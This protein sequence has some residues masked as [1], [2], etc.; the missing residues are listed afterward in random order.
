MSFT[1]NMTAEEVADLDKER[2]KKFYDE[3]DQVTDDRPTKKEPWL[4]K[5]PVNKSGDKD[6]SG[7][8]ILKSFLSKATAVEYAS[9]N[10]DEGEDIEKIAIPNSPIMRSTG[11]DILDMREDAEE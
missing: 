2:G 5:T 6:M 11:C 4:N 3:E 8:D 9:I 10:D 1:P 7:T